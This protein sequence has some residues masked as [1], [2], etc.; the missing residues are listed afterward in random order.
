LAKPS[1]IFRTDRIPVGKRSPSSTVP[2]LPPSTTHIDTTESSKPG[3]NKDRDERNSTSLSH[4]RADT[5][6]GRAVEKKPQADVCLIPES[7]KFL[8]CMPG[9]TPPAMLD[10]FTVS[11]SS[12]L[13]LI[14]TPSI[15]LKS[16]LAQR[17]QVAI[18]VEIEHPRK[19]QAQE[20]DVHINRSAL[21]LLIGKSVLN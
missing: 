13:P 5:P 9:S 15:S 11:I 17:K 19:R 2:Q 7:D 4:T 20:T 1:K 16:S 6:K 12:S 3:G 21:L 18:A 8:K 14:S 10:A